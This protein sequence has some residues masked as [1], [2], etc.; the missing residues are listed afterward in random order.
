MSKVPPSTSEQVTD[1]SA[2]DMSDGVIV[3]DAENRILA[4]NRAAGRMIG[5]SDSNIVGQPIEQ[6][7]PEWSDQIPSRR[8]GVEL[9]KEVMLNQKGEHLSIDEHAHLIHRVVI[10]RG[11]TE[12]SQETTLYDQ[13]QT[14]ERTAEP[15]REI[16]EWARTEARLLQRNRELLSLQSAAIAVAS[17]LD[18]PFVLDTVTW[19]M[20]NLLEVDNC[21][22]YEWNQE[23][24]TISVIAEYDTTDW[25][26]QESGNKSYKLADYPSRKRALVE[27][28][29][30]QMTISQPGIDPA[31]LVRMQKSG[32]KTLLTLPM[33]FQDRVVG[34]V[35][36]KDSQQER[37]FTDHAVSTAQLLANQA[38][39]AVENARLY[40]RAQ[41]EIA[42]R[43]Q[44]EKV[45]R[46]RSR[47]LALLNQASQALN[48]ILDL[49]QGLWTVAEQMI[50][51]LGSGRCTLSRWDHERNMVE[52]LVDYSLIRSDKT[53]LPGTVYDLDG[54]PAMRRVFETRQPVV[55]QHDDQTID[56]AELA[57]LEKR[58]I[59]T[60]L[61][62][63]LIARNQVVGLVELFEE[64]KARDYTS[65][66]IRL[67]QSL[68]AQAA[69]AIEN[70]QLFELAQQEI[71]RRVQVEEELRQH[72]DHLEELVQERTTELTEINE[73]LEQEITERVQ[74]EVE[75]QKAK[76]AAET[77]N[78]AKSVFLANMSHELRTPLNAIIGY[79]ELLEE[80]AKDF[81]YTALI[82]DLGKIEMAGKQLLDIIHNVLDLSK[83]EADKMELALETF[84]VSELI[85]DV[86]ITARPLIERNAN[87]LE[88]HCTDDLGTMH[89][90]RTKVRQVLLNLLSNAAKFTE[91]GTIMLTATRENQEWLR[92]SVA[93]TGIGMVPE[94]VQ[95]LFQP[96]TQAETSTTRKYGGA[97]LGLAISQRFCEMMGGQISVESGERKGSTFTVRLPATATDAKGT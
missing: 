83:I 82:P 56:E 53:N 22:I 21:T 38:A 64:T 35:E 29:A 3:L 97:G 92:F 25:Q 44:A 93:D 41:Q 52:T 49:D 36:I 70:A 88:V 24:D 30:Q 18:L 84:D 61:M 19:E 15:V 62:L 59:Y 77:A 42:E 69:I 90:D 10:L 48:S 58:G 74:A 20:V 8:G 50:Q 57:L 28:Y 4:L 94:T 40:K 95:N 9:R 63:P 34:S 13:L 55:I 2:E 54:Y 11:I 17:S 68:A 67:L 6:V 31:E 71:T 39:I 80:E 32:A 91:E 75:L 89:T 66:E 5:H 81:G 79:S 7:W 16:N 37:I 43:K 96:F 85:R 47:E 23:A 12:G 73:Q 51:F 46:R 60:L 1:R 72:R 45:I 14:S 86:V 33:T 87:T 78:R 65:E 76:K 27:R 26:E